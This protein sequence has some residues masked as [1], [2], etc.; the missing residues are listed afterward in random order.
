LRWYRA[1]FDK[2]IGAGDSKVHVPADGSIP[3]EL[4]CALAEGSL[5]MD[6][7][8]LPCCQTNVSL[9]AVLARLHD[10][11][12]CPICMQ[13]DVFPEMLQENKKLR[14]SAKA[15]M[16]RSTHHREAGRALAAMASVIHF[17]F[18]N[19]LAEDMVTFEGDHVSLAD[20]KRLIAKKKG[21]L[22]AHDIE[23]VISNM[24]TQEGADFSPIA[25]SELV[26]S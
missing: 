9:Q 24:D 11:S 17:K 10:N 25:L 7:V 13:P 14:E 6:A 20:L 4:Q 5:I 26:S 18:R 23:F 2:A 3:K 12:L 1:D 8:I 15:F 16:S 22:E 21:L 19:T